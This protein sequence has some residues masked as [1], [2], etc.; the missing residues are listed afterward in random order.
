MFTHTKCTLGD[1]KGDILKGNTGSPEEI[2][3]YLK[4][5]AKHNIVCL[6]RILSKV[7]YSIALL[8]I[9]TKQMLKSG[10]WGRGIQK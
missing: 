6:V 5:T 1:L 8:E 9:I 10:Q 7:S 2:P 3:G 4:G